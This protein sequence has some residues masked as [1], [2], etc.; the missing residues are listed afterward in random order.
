MCAEM[1]LPNHFL[2]INLNT[3]SVKALIV[4]YIW[5]ADYMLQLG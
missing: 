5:K 2:N 1:G 3:H 4:L